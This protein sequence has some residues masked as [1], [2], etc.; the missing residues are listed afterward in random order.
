MKLQRILIN[1]LG[2]VMQPFSPS[3]K[4]TPLS[5]A[6]GIVGSYL[7]YKSQEE[8]NET[9]LENTKLSSELQQENW[10]NQ[11]QLTNA[12]N[13]PSAARDRLL[14]AGYNPYVDSNSAVGSGQSA[15][16]PQASAPSTSYNPSQGFQNALQLAEI[17]KTMEESSVVKPKAEAEINA[18]NTQSE[19]TRAN[20]EWQKIQNEFG[21]QKAS[22]EVKKLAG[23]VHELYTRSYS[24]DKEAALFDAQAAL[25]KAQKLR[26]LAQSENLYKEGQ[27]LDIEL[28]KYE[29]YW[30]T[31]I[32]QG[33]QDIKTGKA[34]ESEAYASASEHRAAAEEKIANAENIRIWNKI[35]G[36]ARYKHAIISQALDTALNLRKNGQILGEEYKQIIEQVKQ[37]EF[38]T[39]M[40]GFTYWTD[41]LFKLVETTGSA[42][43]Q[44]Y[45]AGAL[46]E[47]GA[48]RRVANQPRV[49]VQGFNRN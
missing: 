45:G 12:Y 40:Q 9:A 46:R 37:L 8:A 39:D 15:F 14:R 24:E 26:E 7:G 49:P 10:E 20:T 33:K 13:D 2:C 31:L 42:A 47:L 1:E 36:D 44:F 23:E 18:Q 11:F 35:Q 32:D 3:R 16:S 34:K 38:V 28:S 41:R 30:N 4:F 25:V 29:T 19:L 6:A 22:E 48:L 27:K 17:V 43:S 5:W 21:R